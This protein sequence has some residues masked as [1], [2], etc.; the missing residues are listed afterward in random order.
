MGFTELTLSCK[1]LKLKLR[2]FLA[3]HIF[4]YGNQLCR[5]VHSNMF[6]NDWVVS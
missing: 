5:K 1:H 3:G 4:C 2:V 6:A